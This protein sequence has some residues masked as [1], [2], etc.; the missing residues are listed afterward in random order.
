MSIP[1]QDGQASTVIYT[2][3]HASGL[4]QLTIPQASTGQQP[5]TTP[6]SAPPTTPV[7]QVLGE[8]QESGL[9]AAQNSGNSSAG[10]QEGAGTVVKVAGASAATGQQPSVTTP[11]SATPWSTKSSV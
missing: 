3:N 9:F 8:Y 11:F 1:N 6:V 5:T 10:Q 4:Q 2:S 7:Q